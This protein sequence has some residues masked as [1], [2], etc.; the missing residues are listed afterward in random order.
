M[1]KIKTIVISLLLFLPVMNAAGQE[2]QRINGKILSSLNEPVKGAIVTITSTENVTTGEDGT[3]AVETLKEAE[4]INVWAPGYYPVSQLIK[5]RQR[6]VIMMIPESRKKYNEAGVLPFR[7]EDNKVEHTSA[8]NISKKD[9]VPGSMKIDRALAGQVAGLKVTR[10]S[11]MPGEGSYMN[12]RGIRSLVADNAP[13][14]VINGVPYLPDSRESQLFNGYTRDIFQS[15]NI[16]DI[17]NITILKGAEAAMYGS[18]GSNGVILIETDGANS[19]DLDTK[20]SF[21]GQYGV[22]WNDK[23]MPLL[24]GTDYKSY[25]SDVG[26]TYFDNMETFYSNFPF[27][28]NPDGKYAYLYNNATDWQDVIY[29][30]G[31]VT[32]NLFRVEGGDA[33]AKYDLS[34]GY[35]G[36]DG[37]IQNT[38]QQ[39]YHTQLNTNVLISKKVEMFA[40]VGLAYMN[41]DYQDQGMVSGT[42]PI[43]AAYKQSPLLS[44]NKMDANGEKLASY[45]TYY[46]GNCTNMDFATSNPLAL[47]NTLDAHS[48]QYDVNVKVGLTYKPLPELALTGV[49]GLYYNYNNERMFVPGVTDKSILPFFDQ[50]G[51]ASNSVKNG[52]GETFNMFYNFNANYKKVFNGVHALNAIAGAQAVMAS[53]EY[54][55]GVGRNTP[56]DFYQTLGN[57][58][59]IG[60]YFYGYCDKWNWMNFY[61]HADYTYNEMIKASV[62]MSVDGSSSVGTYGDYFTMYP[63]VGLT[64]LGKGWLG[65]TNS[66]L[67]N[68]LNVRAEYALTGNSRYSSNYGKFYYQSSP[69]QDIS[70]IV[71]AGIANTKLQPEKNAQLNLGLDVSALH[72]RV[73][74]SVDVY[75]NKATDVIFNVPLSS[76]YGTGSY[77]DNCGEITNRGVELAMQASL[78]NLRDFEWIVGGNIAFNKG[79]VNQLKG[80]DKLVQEYSDGAQLLTQVGE[81]PFHFY[82]YQALGV[83]TTEAAATKANL[84][85]SSGRA[86]EAGDIHY[87]DQN[88]DGRIDYKDRVS[89]GKASPDY[90]GGLFTSVRYKG[91]ELSVD[92]SYS[93]GNDAYNGVRRNLESL[94]NLGNQSV[95][96]VNRWNVE[97]QVTDVPRAAWGDPKGN[98]DFSSRWIEDASYLRMKNITFSYSF[99]KMVLNF[100]RSGKIY[101]TGE[102]LVTATKYLGL[103]PE[104]SYSY[105]DAMQG[106]DYAKQM[107]PK[108]VKLGINLKF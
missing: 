19:N 60:R 83:F 14:V 85:N 5:G 95:S 87:V 34:I 80:T 1:K 101:V 25:L 103:D 81:E 51:E 27:L 30:N 64:W 45:S 86:Y 16:Q 108:A 54:D 38:T 36:E 71:R 79:E 49:L 105:S 97:G 102:N 89:L 40:T 18:L 2:K 56:N 35:A 3:F 6:I 43:L 47:I 82:G 22:T 72:N 50:Y 57:T 98:N 58:Q 39:R 84:V 67:I 13:L 104:F 23:R 42:N 37:L 10:A 63:S 41:G 65:L 33:I 61:A 17:Q 94:S 106:F 68:R 59:G 52:I 20:I 62:N 21:Y 75:Q 74:L 69:Y 15:Y 92:F 46:Y 44:P 76:V 4:R 107:Q 66:T 28:N 24:K 55:A 99:D 100:F 26:M 8:V 48:R 53:Y 9:F 88:G 70:G 11:G 96:V 77:Y 93:K 32:D 78:V 91:F 12:M 73:D 31:F 90:F 7:V 29:R